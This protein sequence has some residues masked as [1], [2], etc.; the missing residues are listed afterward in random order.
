MKK[1][2][3]L[4]VLVL[5]A[6]ALV[7]CGSDDSDTSATTAE[8]AAEAPAGGSAEGG[9]AEAGGSVIK[10]D[11]VDGSGLEFVQKSVTA[12]AGPATIEFTNPQT[13]GHNVEI[14][15]SNGED[16]AETEVITDSKTTAPIDD[17]KP[18]KYTFYC[19]VPGHEEAGM[20]GTLTVE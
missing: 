1:L 15:D 14:E 10:I 11:A 20:K 17:L 7:A 18:G 2:A 16:V 9:S 5:T 13:L 6:I 3:A 12:K 19:S 8:T 4:L